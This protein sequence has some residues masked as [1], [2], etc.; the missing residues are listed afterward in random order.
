MLKDVEQLNRAALRSDLDVTK[1]SYH[2]VGLLRDE[3]VLLRSGGALG[4]GCGP[5]VVAKPN[6][7]LEDLKSKVIAIPGELTTAYLLLR[8]FDPAI[9]N[10]TIMSYDRIMQAVAGGTVAAGLIIHESRFTYPA[11]GL[12]QLV[13]LGEWWE[14][15]SNLPIPLGGILG[16]RSLGRALLLKIE[17]AIR[18]SLQFARHHPD[19]VMDYCAQHAQEVKPEIMKQHI[20]LYVNDFSNDLGN[21]GISA[22]RKLF[23]EAER[24]GFLPRS[25]KPLFVHEM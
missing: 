15:H 2:A 24:R 3:Y 23:A 12:Q 8:L 10:I 7:R 18:E 4:R 25:T 22:V 6:T 9:K 16:K 13:D 19:Q 5:L 11:Y 14:G 17:Q 20:D 21:E 1:V